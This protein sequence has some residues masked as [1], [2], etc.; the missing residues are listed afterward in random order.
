VSWNT[1]LARRVWQRSLLSGLVYCVHRGRFAP[2][3]V[4]GYGGDRRPQR[5]QALGGYWGELPAMLDMDFGE[6]TFH[7]LG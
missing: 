7:A 1:D 5:L 2:L 3:V 6:F 4:G